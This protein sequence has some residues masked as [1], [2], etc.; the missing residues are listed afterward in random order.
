MAIVTFSVR[1]DDIY[2]PAPNAEGHTG[3]DGT[4]TGGDTA[5]SDDVNATMIEREVPEGALTG[6]ESWYYSRSVPRI[7]L[8]ATPYTGTTVSMTL[9]LRMSVSSG[10]RDVSVMLGNDLGPGFDP[11]AFYESVTT[12]SATPTWYEFNDVM[13]NRAFNVNAPWSTDYYQQQGDLRVGFGF[14]GALGPGFDTRPIRLHEVELV[15]EYESAEECYS[16]WLP[17][18]A[19]QWEDRTIGGGLFQQEVDYATGY[20]NRNDHDW[21]AAIAALWATVPTAGT[22]TAT[23]EHSGFRNTNLGGPYTTTFLRWGWKTLHRDESVADPSPVEQTI[24]DD[25]EA[26]SVEW[27]VTGRVAQRLRLSRMAGGDWPAPGEP[28]HVKLEP[29]DPGDVFDPGPL[30]QAGLAAYTTRQE[31]DTSSSVWDLDDLD[32]IGIPLTGAASLTY[33]T[34]DDYFATST[35]PPAPVSGGV[36]WVRNFRVAPQWLVGYQV[37]YRYVYCEVP[38]PEPPEDYVPPPPLVQHPRDDG[39]A[40]PA[41]AKALW[42]PSQFRYDGL[43]RDTSNF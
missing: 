13:T 40:G 43:R 35:V 23:Y 37:E 8:P 3:F 41:S 17:A 31:L 33:S 5:L 42:P 12:V 18:P 29:T 11:Y 28:I 38:D 39:M 6:L 9:R 21:A 2:E 27:R 24:Y 7:V 36:P 1:P 34:V 20:V 10:T 15:V 32:S 22:G 26:L 19:L 30:T 25:P 4:I 16:D 14:T